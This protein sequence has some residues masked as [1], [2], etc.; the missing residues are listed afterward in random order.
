MVEH[1]EL[2][3]HK[4]RSRI[5]TTAAKLIAAN[6]SRP[7]DRRPAIPI[8]GMR[9]MF[10]LTFRTTATTELASSQEGRSVAMHL[11]AQCIRAPSFV[12]DVALKIR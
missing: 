2:N 7:R 8:L 1:M 11:A 12:T 9:T 10:K 5:S 3:E 4:S 6:A